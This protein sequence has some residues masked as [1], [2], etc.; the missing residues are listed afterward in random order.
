V[1]ALPLRALG[2]HAVKPITPCHA[3]DPDAEDAVRRYASLFDVAFGAVRIV[4]TT[5]ARVSMT[6]IDHVAPSGA[7]EAGG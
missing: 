3:F 1:E 7:R 2:D 5:V 4:H 6:T